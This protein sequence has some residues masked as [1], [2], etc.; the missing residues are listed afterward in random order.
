[1]YEAFNSNGFKAKKED[2]N[3]PKDFKPSYLY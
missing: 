1:M 3:L 2:L